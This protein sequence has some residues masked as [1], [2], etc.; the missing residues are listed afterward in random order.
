MGTIWERGR[1]R[2][3]AGLFVAA[4]L[5]LVT[6]CTVKP[7]F[8]PDSGSPGGFGDDQFVEADDQIRINELQ[9]IGSHNSYH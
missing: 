6:A 1:N 5:T 2:R 4:A 9:Y 8:N 7:P 3:V